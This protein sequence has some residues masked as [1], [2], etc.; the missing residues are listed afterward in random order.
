MKEFLKNQKVTYNLMSFT[1]YKAL[2]LFSLLTEGAK[3][4]EE[5]RTYFLNHPYLQESI[6]IDTLRVYINSLKRIGCEVKRIRGEDK[7]SRYMIL[8]HPFELKLTLEQVKSIEKVYKSIVKNMDIKELLAMDNLFEKIGNY[9]KDEDFIQ[10]MKRISMLKDVDKN[11]LQELLDC[12]E[13]KEQIIIS[14]NSPNS[15]TKDIEMISDKV[16]VLNGKVYLY[17]FGFEYNQYG[18]F[19]ISRINCIKD[20]KPSSDTPHLQ[21]TKVVYE[22]NCSPEKIALSE[23]ERVIDKNNNKTIIEAI[24]SNKFLLNQKLLEYGP[25][26]KIIYPKDYKEQF[27]NLLNDMKAGYYCD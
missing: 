17:G 1:G 12:C 15:G 8:S 11:L 25:L 18:T 22:L 21:T 2:I 19:L 3:S 16:E 9:I 7:I 5:I 6:S 23:N 14:Y 24:T 26:C 10:N 27:V 20:I 4:Y 13:K